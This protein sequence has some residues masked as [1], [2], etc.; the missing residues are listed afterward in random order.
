MVVR[1]EQAR[2]KFVNGLREGQVMDLLVKIH[3]VLKF[4]VASN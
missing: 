3:K 1:A 4:V 2:F